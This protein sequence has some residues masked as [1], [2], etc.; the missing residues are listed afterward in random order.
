MLDSH[1]ILDRYQFRWYPTLNQASKMCDTL[2]RGRD[3][4][5]QDL[6]YIWPREYTDDRKR[7]FIVEEP[8]KF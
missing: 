8:S 1:A 5:K 7:Y 3:E 4:H 2:N 6:L